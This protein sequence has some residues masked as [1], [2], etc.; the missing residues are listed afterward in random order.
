MEPG[1]IAP[2]IEVDP[3]EHDFGAISAGSETSDVIINIENLGNGDLILDN[4]YLQGG[5]SNFSISLLPIDVIE[6]SASGELV[7]TY[8]PG[9]YEV[10]TDTISILS[11]DED[12]PE[13]LVVLDGSGD[14]PVITVNPD[15]Y[16][17]GTI[18]LGCDDELEIDVGNIA[19][20]A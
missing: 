18:Y 12:E 11:N 2:E 10:N 17:F 9:T 13:V 4:I 20:E 19:P 8:S 16:D 6:P 1:E 3:V 7:V 14:A 5:N 15:Y